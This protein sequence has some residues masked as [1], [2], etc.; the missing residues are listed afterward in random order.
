M[1]N[2]EKLEAKL[3]AMTFADFLVGQSPTKETLVTHLFSAK[4]MRVGTTVSTA[5]SLATPRLKMHC[6]SADCG[7]IRLFGFDKSLNGLDFDRTDPSWHIFMPRYG[8]M[9]CQK[10]WKTF[11]LRAQPNLDTIGKG[12]GGLVEK[13]GEDPRFGTPT[14]QRLLTL[15]GDQKPTFLLGRQCENQG[16]GIGAFGYY[17]R[18]VENLKLKLF[19]RL[20]EVAETVDPNN[21]DL[22]EALKAAGAQNQFSKAVETIKPAMPQILLINGHNPLTLL[23]RALSDGLHEQSDSHCLELA[24]TVR[25][26]LAHL[27][28]RMHQALQQEKELNAA[29]SRLMN[30]NGQKQKKQETE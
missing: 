1:A 9:N 4:A 18:V 28:D 15:L 25:L 22:I 8:C 21:T 23:H 2:D 5:Y 29:I 12:N 19:D 14:P 10:A 20:I 13:L 11:A 7:G 24:H 17:R 3:E 6:W 16:L 26:V 30:T 27:A